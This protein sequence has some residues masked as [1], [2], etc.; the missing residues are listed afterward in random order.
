MR[1]NEVIYTIRSKER[2]RISG[3]VTIRKIGKRR[4][5]ARYKPKTQIFI[6]TFD[7]KG[8]TQSRKIV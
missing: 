5:K 4:Y 2:L 6:I 1:N 8:L 3:E 7:E